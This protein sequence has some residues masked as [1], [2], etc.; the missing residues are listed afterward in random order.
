M[1]VI[2]PTD[3]EPDMSNPYASPDPEQS[4]QNAAA[5]AW[6]STPGAPSGPYG[7]ASD[8]QSSVPASSWTAQPGQSSPQPFYGQ[9]AEQ[10]AQQ[11]AGAW[12][13]QQPGADQQSGYGQ[14][15]Y[16]QAPY[17]QGQPGAYPGAPYQQAPYGYGPASAY[18]DVNQLRSNSTIVLVLGIIS[19]VV[20][21]L[22]TAIPAWIWGNSL[23]R[24]A[25]DAGLPDSV[26]SNAKIGRILGMVYC[27]IAAAFLVLVIIFV[28]I[29]IAVGSSGY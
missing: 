18:V 6:S 12:S 8:G 17:G 1:S 21:S 23:M 7:P 22:L 5:D 25:R 27:G 15:P 14:A 26:V 13:A 29:G 2:S 9:A 28:I 4:G 11:A 19:F 16:G 24:Q 20:G 10:Q 3:K